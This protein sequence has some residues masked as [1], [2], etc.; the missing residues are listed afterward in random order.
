MANENEPAPGNPA[1]AAPESPPETAITIPGGPDGP[2]TDASRSVPMTAAPTPAWLGKVDL[3]LLGLILVLSFLVGSIPAHNPDVWTNLATGRL[4]AGGGYLPTGVDPFSCST[5]DVAWVNHSWLYD[6]TL[7][8][9]YRGLGAAGV[10][11]VKALLL[12]GIALLMMRTRQRDTHL[13]LAVICLTLAV[14]ALSLRAFLQPALVSCLFLAATLYVLNRGGVFAAAGDSDPAPDESRVLWVLPALFVVWV[15]VDNWF[16]LGPI[17]VGLCWAG[18]ALQRWLG[19]AGRVPPGRLG[20]VFGVG[21]L[22]CLLN[23]FHVRAF[24]LPPE[25]AYLLLGV[26]DRF[27][28]P[29]PDFLVAG[30]RTL[31]VLRDFEPPSQALAITLSPLSGTFASSP[32]LGFNVAGISFYGL[33]GLSLASF[34]LAGAAGRQPGGPAPQ[35][36]RFVVWVFFAAL[37]VSLYRVIPFFAVVA[38]PIA[39]LNLG[40]LLAWYARPGEAGAPTAPWVAPA[41]A[42]RLL[43][44]PLVLALLLLAWPGWLHGPFEFGSSRHVGW[45]IPADGTLR[46]TA[47]RLGELRSAGEGEHVFNIGS[48]VSGLDVA[49]YC[50]WF[51]PGVKCFIDTRYNLFARVAREY[52]TAREALHDK[53]RPSTAWSDVFKAYAIHHVTL[54]NFL[55]DPEHPAW[56]VEPGRWRQRFADRNLA[57][58]TWSGPDRHWPS[59]TLL[60]DW[61][62]QAFGTVPEAARP[63]AKGPPPPPEPPGLVDRYLWPGPPLPEVALQS[64]VL[65]TYSQFII[66]HATQVAD[67]VLE[68]FPYPKSY[69]AAGLPDGPGSIYPFALPVSAMVPPTLDKLAEEA[70][71][72]KK[73][74]PLFFRPPDVYPPALPILQTRLAWQAVAEA[75]GN[76]RCYLYLANAFERAQRQEANWTAASPAPGLR[77]TLRRIQMITA[78]RTLAELGSGDARVL[79]QVNNSLANTFFEDDFLD[80]GLEH[81]V[82]ADQ[83]LEA[84]RPTEPR[85]LEAF[86]AGKKEME[87]KIKAIG[88]EIARRR[89]DFD[90]KAASLKPLGRVKVAIRLPYQQ[91]TQEN[92]EVVFRTRGLAN[93]ALQVLQDTDPKSLTAAEQAEW[94]VTT[95]DLL[96]RTGHAREASVIL[97]KWKEDLGPQVL[98]F[99]VL[100]AGALGDYDA[101]RKALG[102]LEA[103]L[104]GQA[105]ETFRMAHAMGLMAP[106]SGLGQ[107][108]V[109][110]GLCAAPEMNWVGAV[111]AWYVTS[112][113]YFGVKTLRGLAALEAGDTAD[114][115]RAFGEIVR[116]ASGS[117]YFPDFPIAE[118]YAEFLGR[119]HKK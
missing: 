99:E 45:D 75:P 42:V 106:P 72:Q 30:G 95:L 47:E 117:F 44:L 62:A 115:S 4:I 104:A 37:A 5:G 65:A 53:S 36:V 56:W 73:M 49:P 93:L 25:L 8:L 119:Y 113:Q 87:M 61:G 84:L 94:V 102:T 100:C 69:A 51:A 48:G 66:S 46:A 52:G 35:V 89:K 79:Y 58:F 38:G 31:Q 77:T 110:L 33:L 90:L 118:R 55:T 59:D 60:A 16:V 111:N 76:E 92:K 3:A 12:V 105:K 108:Y 34:M 97:S 29:L 15:N 81:L 39:A 82:L 101:M 22:A 9:L 63:P 21:L 17:T 109:M 7:Y 86:L 20:A 91:M 41:R 54:R 14:L 1:A 116:E 28:L 24:Q 13:F 18:A 88:D 85:Q 23:P 67:K 27:G 103:A 68:G 11:V 50:A 98:Q 71:K 74:R 43:S 64:D 70:S 96:L 6:L 83:A 10:V 107:A 40:E 26:T 19:P 2:A 78:L 112:Q 80:V 114:A 32:V 57:L